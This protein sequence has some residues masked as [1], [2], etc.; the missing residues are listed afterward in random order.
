MSL[1]SRITDLAVAIRDKLNLMTP[2]LIPSG[3]SVGQYV[4]KTGASPDTFGWAT[5]AG[6]GGGSQEV[7]VQQ[8]S[9]ISAG[10]W[11]WWKTDADGDI[12]DLIIEDGT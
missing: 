11:T 1:A 6:G 12:I 10:P 4:Q 5:P 2:R 7:F 8:T 9:P 3:E